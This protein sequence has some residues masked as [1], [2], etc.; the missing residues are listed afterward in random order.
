MSSP[1]HSPIVTR[2]HSNDNIPPQIATR[3]NDDPQI[4]IEPATPNPIG[5]DIQEIVRQSLIRTHSDLA[6]LRQPNRTLDQPLDFSEIREQLR[7]TN[8]TVNPIDPILTPTA[9]GSRIPPL[10]PPSS[11]SSLGGDSSDEGSSPSQPST[12]TTPM[13]N[14]NNLARPWLDLDAVDV[15]GDQHPLPK[16]LE[17][18]LPKFDP[19]SKQ[20]AEYHIK[21]F[22]LA[23]R[24]HNVKH[25][26]VVC[27]LFAYTFEGN[28]STWYF[29]QQPHTIVS[30]EN[31]ESCFLE[32]F[33]DDKSPEVL[34]MELSSLKM[35]PKEKIKDFNQ[36]FL[37]LKNRI[38]MDLMPA[39]NLIIAYYTK[40]LHQSIAIWVKQSK[41]A[42][43]LEAFEEASQIE[44]DILSLKDTTSNETETSSSSKKKIKILPRPTQSKTQPERSDLE[45]LTK[46]IQKLSNQV[47]DLKRMI[48]EASLRK[49][50]YKPPF[51]KPFPTNRP[52]LNTEGL[53]LESL[54]YTLQT[55]L[56][57]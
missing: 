48:E 8:L 56:E 43:L 57:A 41:K 40:D 35:N 14:Q 1:N 27:R 26:D 24:L 33:G 4:T 17:K 10:P 44:K 39:E 6:H 42:T 25:E 38:P 45:N 32:K 16:H 15:P 12:L 37:T 5:G 30:W 52:N 29:S 13:A 54:Q 21:F 46:F 9:G 53:N 7:G 20:I 31:F 50:P 18:W 19:D 22:M 47:I 2:S 51:R 34:V 28:A 49:G 36:R 55:I 11:P 3:S 23:I